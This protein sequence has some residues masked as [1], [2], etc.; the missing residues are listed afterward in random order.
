MQGCKYH[1]GEYLV[2]DPRYNLLAISGKRLA[3]IKK[4]VN[5]I[6]I[7]KYQQNIGKYGQT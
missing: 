3:N 2:E 5:K 7:V 1:V 4:Y 6:I